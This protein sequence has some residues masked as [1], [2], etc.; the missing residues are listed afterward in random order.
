M[1]Q[2]SIE[3]FNMLKHIAYDPDDD[4]LMNENEEYIANTLNER[5]CIKWNLQEDG[6]ELA[7]VSDI[8]Y[9]AMDCFKCVTK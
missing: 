8:G 2:L 9:I 4:E 3:Q 7:T 1:C 6:N 5:G